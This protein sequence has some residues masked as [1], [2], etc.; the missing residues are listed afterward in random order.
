MSEIWATC[1]QKGGV[2]KTTTVVNLAAY[3]AASG[4]KILLI[5]LDPQG[6]ATSGLGINRSEIQKCIYNALIEEVKLSDILKK[7]AIDNLSLA[8]ATTALAGAEV[9]LIA[10]LSRETRLKSII[11]SIK[12]QYDYILID[13]PPS[14]SILTINALTAAQKVLIPIQ[15]EYYALEGISRLVETIE[16]IRKRLNP[17]LEIKG[18]LLTMFDQRTVISQQVANEVR[19]HF[20]DRVFNTVIPRNV[21]LSESPSFGQPIMLYDKNSSGAIAYEALSKEVSLNGYHETGI[22]QGSVRT[23]S[24][25]RVAG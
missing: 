7:T 14:L 12:D 13:C 16:L 9:E 4:K 17:K 11:D 10:A 18:I 25:E 24:A 5:D 21:R 22:G 8:P 3:L 20:K 15:C 19:N 6:N 2:G 23:D 1:N